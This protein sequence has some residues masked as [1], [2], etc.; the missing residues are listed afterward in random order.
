MDTLDLYGLGALALLGLIFTIVRRIPLYVA[1]CLLLVGAFLWM[2]I[3]LVDWMRPGEWMVLTSGLLLCCFGLLIV[4]VM[5][6][7]S[8]SLQLLRRLAG[9]ESGEGIRED[10]G[11]RLK[12]M[13]FFRLIRRGEENRLTAFGWFCST[14]VVVFYALFRIK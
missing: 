3:P 13:E 6:I 12:D 10:I 14:V 5:L 8:V 1:A 2:T 4:R 11:G 7:R 9:G